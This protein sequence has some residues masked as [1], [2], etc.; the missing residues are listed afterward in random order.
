MGVCFPLSK[1]VS[2]VFLRRPSGRASHCSKVKTYHHLSVTLQATTLDL[3]A[4]DSMNDWHCA[5][6]QGKGPRKSRS[7]RRIEIHCTARGLESRACKQTSWIEGNF[8]AVSSIFFHQ[9]LNARASAGRTTE[10]ARTF[11]TALNCSRVKC[12]ACTLTGGHTKGG[13]PAPHETPL[14]TCLHIA[15]KAPSMNTDS[16]MSLNW[17]ASVIR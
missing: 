8:R 14:A 2:D 5:A 3:L 13:S 9:N 12:A 7:A 17:Y 10:R 1:E 11:C 16:G 4:I 6:K 15:Q